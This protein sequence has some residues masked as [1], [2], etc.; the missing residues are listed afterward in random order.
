MFIL[1]QIECRKKAKKKLP[2]FH[3][4]NCLYTKRS[5][6][7]ATSEMVAKFKSKIF[8]G[9][10]L[11]DLCGGLGVD[12]YWLSQSFQSITSLDKNNML[13][14]IV[15]YN[16]NL[17]LSKNHQRLDLAAEE[18]DFTAIPQDSTIYID[19]DRR[20][21]N[22]K[23][24]FIPSLHSPNVFEI[25]EKVL[26]NTR[27][28]LKLSPMV[29]LSL[30]Q[31][32]IPNITAI[33]II[34]SNFENKELLI[35]INGSKSKGLMSVE[36][37]KNGKEHILTK[38]EETHPIP[39]HHALPYLIIPSASIQ[40]AKMGNTL[41]HTFGLS[42]INKQYNFLFSSRQLDIPQARVLSILKQIPYKPKQINREL[43]AMH[44]EKAEL[45]ARDFFHKTEVLSKKLNIKKGGEHLLVFTK[46]LQEN[47]WVLI[48]LLKNN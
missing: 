18:Y 44:I 35:E 29:D 26:D 10:F 21:N 16:N 1:E 43:K 27:V 46:D 24:Q 30:I 7:Q 42:K 28:I 3:K 15:R 14:E 47:G 33:W 11:L 2:F 17:L 37:D 8:E 48:C 39:I 13:N 31:K 23:R 22:G 12:D 25:L 38:H 9:K 41:A 32:Q 45:I 6:E 36:I 20:D 40:K 34:S 19:P 4:S 5:L